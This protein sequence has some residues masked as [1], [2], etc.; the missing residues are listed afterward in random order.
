MITNNNSWSLGSSRRS[1]AKAE[2]TPNKSLGS[3]AAF[4]CS[5]SSSDPLLNPVGTCSIHVPNLQLLTPLS[6]PSRPIASLKSVKSVLSIG[7]LLGPLVAFVL[8]SLGS[9]PSLP[10]LPFRALR[11]PALAAP[12]NTL[13]LQK[14]TLN[15][16][17]IQRSNDPTIQRSNH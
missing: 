1:F 11:L 14:N 10:A 17:T 15:D 13:S 9:F 16:P 12:K 8:L 3:S 4:I 7:L 6:G 2:A 5:H